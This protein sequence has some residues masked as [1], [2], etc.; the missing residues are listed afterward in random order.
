MVMA[1]ENNLVMTETPLSSVA[2]EPGL[3]TK[4]IVASRGIIVSPTVHPYL[5]TASRKFRN[6]LLRLAFFAI[7][8]FLYR[9]PGLV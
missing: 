9:L 3:E 6:L 8:K 5:L 7:L 4:A 1:L 2:V